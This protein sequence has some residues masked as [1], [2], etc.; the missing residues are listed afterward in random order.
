MPEMP[1]SK[2]PK[3]LNDRIA[4]V[5][6]ATPGRRWTAAELAEELI[7]RYPDWAERK[8]K[9]SRYD[10][11]DAIKAEIYANRLALQKGYPKIVTTEERPKRFF[12]SDSWTVGPE[13]PE[14]IQ[15]T[16]PAS[17]SKES[18]LYPLSSR[19]LHTENGLWPKR[20]DE[21]AAAKKAAGANRWLFPDLVA[22][23]LLGEK[24]PET[25]QDLVR[26]MSGSRVRL[27]SFEVKSA[28]GLTNVRE[29]FFQTVSNSSWANFGYLVAADIVADGSLDE[30]RVLAGL[31]G[32][33]VI[34]L[35]RSDPS[36]SEILIPARERPQVDWASVARLAKESADFARFVEAVRGSVR[37]GKPLVDQFDRVGS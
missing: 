24:W 11:R 29:A 34:R 3:T 17:G 22:M 13:S 30:L 4:A 32:I 33:G 2:E 19:Y 10:L 28:L 6:R 25:V 7:E 26:E 1:A 9:R 27:W 14:A 16:E 31:H 15:T 20:I 8:R 23:E 37:A 12:W 36:E 21:K 5:L 35:D 18:D